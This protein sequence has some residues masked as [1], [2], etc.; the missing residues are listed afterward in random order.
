LIYCDIPYCGTNCG[1]Y[2]GFN[3]AEFYEW[4]KSQD[5]IYISEYSMPSE[6]FIQIAQIDKRQLS[7]ANGA[8][9]LVEEKIYTNHRTYY[10]M[11]KE[12]Q[13]MVMLNQAKQMTMF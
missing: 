2:G 6:D 3:H 4:A 5:N 1:K 10:K 12:Q 13:R 8:S 7:T 11:T 9:D